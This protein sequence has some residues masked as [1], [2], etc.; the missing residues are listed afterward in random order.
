MVRE[1][2][3]HNKIKVISEEHG[4]QEV[5]LQ[6][7]RKWDGQRKVMF[8]VR[9]IPKLAEWAPFR[10]LS[11]APKEAES[12]EFMA[13]GSEIIM[14]S[15]TGKPQ[16]FK[17]TYQRV[18][19]QGGIVMMNVA[20]DYASIG[21]ASDLTAYGNAFPVLFGLMYIGK[22]L[23]RLPGASLRGER[24]RHALDTLKTQRILHRSRI[25]RD[26]G[27][28]DWQPPVQTIRAITPPAGFEGKVNGTVSGV[29]WRIRS[30]TGA[31][32]IH[33]EVSNIV[34]AT[35]Q[36]IAFTIPLPDATG[37]TIG[38][39]RDAEY[40][41]PDGLA[42]FSRRDPGAEVAEELLRSDIGLTNSASLDITSAT[43]RFHLARRHIGS[44][45]EP[46]WRSARLFTDGLCSG[47]SRCE[48]AHLAA[49]PPTH[50]HRSSLR[51]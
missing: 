20:E 47:R 34:A 27:R 37:R 18:G 50:Q 36:A 2:A 38:E 31:V 16:V 40:R 8:T 32:S 5:M 22:G 48:Y 15:G 44:E 19:Q 51:A 23:L 46:E 24:L 30:T 41:R 9:D 11:S 6:I 10:Y 7:C 28:P 13:A 29:I 39:S 45:S 21:Q 4:Q 33:S 25:R 12:P 17:G 3:I 35:N 14:L 1:S 26:H 43:G 49:I 42:L